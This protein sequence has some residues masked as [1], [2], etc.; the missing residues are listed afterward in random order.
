MKLKEILLKK[1][2]KNNQQ[3]TQK[4]LEYIGIE[5]FILNIHRH[6]FLFYASY[7]QIHS[8]FKLHMKVS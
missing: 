5:C 4:V 3:E 7:S 6:H 1:E 8:N 2:K